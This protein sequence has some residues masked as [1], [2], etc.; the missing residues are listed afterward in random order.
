MNPRELCLSPRP[1]ESEPQQGLPYDPSHV[2]G[3]WKDDGHTTCT[4]AGLATWPRPWSAYPR[5]C[6]VAS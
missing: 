1:P 4:W 5:K 6:R 2:C 3:R